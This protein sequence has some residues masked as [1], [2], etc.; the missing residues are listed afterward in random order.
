MNDFQERVDRMAARLDEQAPEAWKPST[1]GEQIV[2][3]FR[4]LEGPKHDRLRGEVYIAVLELEPPSGKLVSVWLLH[5]ALKNEFARKR[6]DVGSVVAIRYLGKQTPAGGGNAY[7][8][9]RVEVERQPGSAVGWDKIGSGEPEADDAA[10]AGA[11]VG[12]VE[13]PSLQVCSECRAFV[14]EGG[15]HQPGCS[16]G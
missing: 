14:G 5:T 3:V 10:D 7:D 4:G 15:P 13:P 12:G 1:A 11:P 16:R 6:P 8:N 2:G 9:Y